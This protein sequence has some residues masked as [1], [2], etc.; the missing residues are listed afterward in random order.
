MKT[1]LSSLLVSALL[2]CAS[3][4]SRSGKMAPYRWT[5]LSE[6]VDSLTLALEHGFYDYHPLDSL[7]EAVGRL[8]SAAAVSGDSLAV[9][10]GLY[11]RGQLLNRMGETDSALSVVSRGIEMVDSARTPYDF[12]RLRGLVR[13]YSHSIG[14]ESYREIDEEARFYAGIGDKPMTATMYINLA[15]TLLNLGDYDKSLR[16][17]EQADD[18]NR[19]LGFD[20]RVAKNKINIASI[21][22]RKGNRE[23]GIELLRELL[24]SPEI[25]ADDGAYNLVL[26]NLYVYTHDL[27][28]L[29]K[30]YSGVAGNDNRRDLQGLYEA[31][32]SEH[33]HD[34]GEQDSAVAYSRLAI[35]NINYVDNFAH[36]SMIMQVYA[37]A[38]ERGGQIDSALRYQKRYIE[39]SDSD[40]AR[41]QQSEVLRIANL[42]EVAEV[43][44]RE[45]ESAQNTRFYFLG[46][47]FAV[48][49][50]AGVVYFMLYRRQK[51]HEMASRDSRLEMEKSRRSLL[52][53]MLV[54]EEKDNLFN[55][56]NTEIE[57]MRKENSIG[58]PEAR[59]LQNTIQTHL[60]GDED[61]KSFQQQFVQIYPV[62]VNK[63]LGAYPGLADSYVKLATFIY[64]GLDNN[65]IARL[66]VIRPESVKQARW[67]LR[68]M[69]NLD[70]DTS[71]DDAI[72][73]LG[74]D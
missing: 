42:R 22:F 43:M 65:R 48:L 67:R 44:S 57:K 18:I 62:F 34:I 74:S 25:K 11:W 60:S 50:V 52:A 72:R 30:A 27:S 9:A 7:E 10:R 51:R 39:Y 29:R 69:M 36:K 6:E 37:E 71:L 28:Y 31:L 35:N 23:K 41:M 56:L 1:L 15:I 24:D 49:T 8:E 63:L 40:Y 3:C 4:G 2:L 66:L 54:V 21:H 64:M 53:M 13:Q 20:K 73:A 46:A 33:F 55:F 5:A 32:L 38:M 58:A 70:K 61:W 19:S 45:R 12:F 68:R 17:M 47:I 14:A 16:Y 59:R 26:R